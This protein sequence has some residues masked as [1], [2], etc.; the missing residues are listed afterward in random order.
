[1]KCLIVYTLIFISLSSC[2]HKNKTGKQYYEIAEK[3]YQNGRAKKASY[4][5][6]KAAEMD[7]KYDYYV[8]AAQSYSLSHNI[9]QLK[10][11][12]RTLQ[13]LN[14]SF[15]LVPWNKEALYERAQFFE[16]C[17]KY[18]QAIVDLDSLIS[19]YPSY[20]EGYKLKGKILIFQRDLRNGLA[21]FDNAISKVSRKDLQLIYNYKGFSCHQKGYWRESANA[22][23]QELK[24]VGDSCFGSNYCYLSSAYY[25]L[26]IKDS[27]CFYFKKCAIN[28]YPALNSKEEMVKLCD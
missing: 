15:Q 23:Q 1:M 12:E 7:K 25:N 11:F 21:A 26:G 6:Y 27:S 19:K 28:K 22:Y 18:N 4:Y 13:I 24:L 17:T 10:H 14:K 9:F 5:Y 2:I 16:Y 20:V 3:Y 8:K